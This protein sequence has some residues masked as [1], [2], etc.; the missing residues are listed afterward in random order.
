LFPAFL[1]FILKENKEERKRLVAFEDLF[2]ITTNKT[3]KIY[4]T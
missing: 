4:H 3:P 1:Y 2:K